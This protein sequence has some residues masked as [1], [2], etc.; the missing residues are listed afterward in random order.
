MTRDS[1]MTVN[2]N[3]NTLKLTVTTYDYKL[4][5]K[6]SINLKIKKV[7]LHFLFVSHYFK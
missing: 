1:S 7:S 5:N 3:R 4:G 2:I 6:F